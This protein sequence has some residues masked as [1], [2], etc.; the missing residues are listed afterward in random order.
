MAGVA[1]GRRQVYHL[2]C[3]VAQFIRAED[4]SSALHPL[5]C[6]RFGLLGYDVA[7]DGVVDLVERPKVETVRLVVYL[8]A[9]PAEESA[10]GDRRWDVGEGSSGGPLTERELE[11]LRYLVPFPLEDALYRISVHLLIIPTQSGIQS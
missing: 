10:T 6:P 11:V 2:I 1:V 5:R 3:S 7:V 4:G 9:D 8:F